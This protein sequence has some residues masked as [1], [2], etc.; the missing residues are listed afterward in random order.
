LQ[1]T[2]I[3]AR[4]HIFLPSLAGL[5]HW[6]DALPSHEWL[7]Y[8]H[9]PFASHNVQTMGNFSWAG[10]RFFGGERAGPG[11]DFKQTVFFA[12]LPLVFFGGVERGR[13]EFAFG[14]QQDGQQ[15][16]CRPENPARRRQINF[17]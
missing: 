12:D 14:V 11:A 5:F 2:I 9:F 4:H 1:T 6:A 7:G 8:F 3:C 13:P 10:N 15:F 17:D 16:L